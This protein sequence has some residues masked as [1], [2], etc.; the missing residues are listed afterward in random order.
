[1]TGPVGRCH[2]CGRRAETG[3]GGRVSPGMRAG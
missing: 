1:V 3:G 2:V